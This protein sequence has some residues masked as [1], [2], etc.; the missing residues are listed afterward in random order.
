V[1]ESGRICAINQLFFVQESG[2]FLYEKLAAFC[3]INRPFFMQESSRNKSAVFVQ[4]SGH[5]LYKKSA[6]FCARKRLC[7]EQ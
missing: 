4:E 6:A 2:C 1:Q 3:A 7:S 5:F